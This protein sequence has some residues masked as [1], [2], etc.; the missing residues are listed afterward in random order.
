MALCLCDIVYQKIYTSR[1]EHWSI[2]YQSSSKT[3]L[4]KW[5]RYPMY[6]YYDLVTNFVL[7]IQK[8]YHTLMCIFLRT[9][10]L[11]KSLNIKNKRKGIIL[12]DN[13]SYYLFILA[14]LSSLHIWFQSFSTELKLRFP[15]S[16][17]CPLRDYTNKM[18]WKT[19]ASSLF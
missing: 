1:F 6:K 15:Q 18:F 4:T 12:T 3:D 17:R 16:A 5:Y 8:L 14:I 13:L 10:S 19:L 2:Y 9:P 7:K 11:S